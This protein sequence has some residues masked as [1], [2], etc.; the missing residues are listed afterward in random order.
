MPAKRR[1]PK[2]CKSG[3]VRDPITKRCRKDKRMSPKKKSPS[4]RKS[5]LT[6][7]NFFDKVKMK[8]PSPADKKKKSPSKRGRGRPRLSPS[9]RKAP[10]K[11]SLRPCKSGSKRNPRTNR[12][13]KSK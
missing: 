5:P 11:K 2:P 3:M 4:K 10:K 1:S 13:V 6:V 8:Y 7:A 9:A 12:C